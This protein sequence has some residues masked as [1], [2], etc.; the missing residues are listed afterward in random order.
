MKLVT[1][2]RKSP[3]GNPEARG[4]AG[5]ASLPLF[6]GDIPQP[7]R[8]SQAHC[9]DD[10]GEQT[11]FY[12]WGSAARKNNPQRLQADWYPASGMVRRNLNLGC[13]LERLRRPG[14][15]RQKGDISECEKT[16]RKNK[17]RGTIKHV[18]TQ[19]QGARA[20]MQLQ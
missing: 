13:A 18:D 10:D 9:D 20:R 11:E 15:I 19:G 7:K 3:K 17:P 12:V 4:P 2:K 16:L 1:T 6:A 8:P 5:T 14:V